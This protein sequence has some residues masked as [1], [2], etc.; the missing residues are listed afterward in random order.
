VRFATL[1]VGPPFYW[2]STGEAVNT[3]GHGCPSSYDRGLF[4]GIIA[5]R[6]ASSLHVQ[7][8]RG[9]AKTIE[10]FVVQEQLP[11]QPGLS[12]VH[13]GRLQPDTTDRNRYLTPA[14]SLVAS[15]KNARYLSMG[16]ISRMPRPILGPRAA[17]SVNFAIVIGTLATIPIII[18]LDQGVDTPWVRAADWIVWGIFVAEYVIEIVCALSRG[19]Y[20]RRNWVSPIVIALSFPP[21]PNLLA[22]VRVARL[23]RL[24]RFSRVAGTTIRGLT[25]LRSVLVRRGLVYVGLMTLILILGGAAALELVEPQAI[26][27]GYLDGVWWAIVTASTVGYGDIAP[28]TF[29]GR[30]IAIALM[31]AGIGLVSTFSASV[32]SHF[33]GQQEAAELREIRER[34]ARMEALLEQLT[35]HGT[36]AGA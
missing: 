10:T 34:L 6:I 24:L 27:G 26:R 2:C 22:A 21:L 9:C 4:T 18:L 31:L 1:P 23:A 30:V 25:E 29:W 35:Q 5:A 14:R 11:S 36:G 20:A 17:W 13:D 8:S 19:E 15:L 32:T 28:S 33:V 3:P 7:T 12:L 16:Y